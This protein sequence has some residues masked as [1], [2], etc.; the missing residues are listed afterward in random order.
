MRLL[1]L[2]GTQ[3]LLAVAM[4]AMVGAGLLWP[5]VMALF[6]LPVFLLYVIWAIRA[7]YDHRLSIWL[8]FV[9]TLAVAV[10]FGTIT[11]RGILDL[12][13]DRGEPGNVNAQLAVDAAGRVV[14]LSADMPP[15]ARKTKMRADHHDRAYRRAYVGIV[16]L[17]SVAGWLV[18]ILAV[19]EWRWLAGRT[20]KSGFE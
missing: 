17:I 10:I 3:V 14:A 13:A 5:G 4:A 1:I 12:S 19:L 20:L 7:A 9:M 11:F 8:C 18:V 6:A 15:G 16:T 2:K